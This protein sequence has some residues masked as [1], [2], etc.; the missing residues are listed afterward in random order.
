MIKLY[1]DIFSKVISVQTLTDLVKYIRLFSKDGTYIDLSSMET[2]EARPH[3]PN[4]AFRLDITEELDK[5]PEVARIM[6]FFK[7][8]NDTEVEIEIVDR[9]LVNYR[10][11]YENTVEGPRIKMNKEGNYRTY[12]LKFEVEKNDEND[13]PINCTFYPNE[14]FESFVIRVIW[15]I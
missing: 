6:I 7:S 5:L 1:P 4:I 14:N 12:S 10:R 2:I 15:L 13:L 11:L 9:K 3:H 8:F